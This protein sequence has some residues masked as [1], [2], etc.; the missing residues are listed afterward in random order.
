MLKI[1]WVTLDLPSHLTA[2]GYECGVTAYNE[3]DVLYLLNDKNINLDIRTIKEISSS[4]EFE[5]NHV[6]LNIGNPIV[7]SVCFP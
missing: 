2:F 4:N 7:R 5:Q 1:F 6:K 3:R